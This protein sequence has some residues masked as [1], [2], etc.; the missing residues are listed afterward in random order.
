M[1]DLEATFAERRGQFLEPVARRLEDHL[2][3]C[4][5]SSARVDRIVA[6]AKRVDRFLAKATKVREDGSPKYQLP[7]A[8]I[9]DQIAARIVT[10]YLSDVSRISTEINRFFR[11]IERKLIVPDSENEFGYFGQHFILLIPTDVTAGLEYPDAPEF[12]ELQI[13]T[14]FQHAWAEAEHDVGYKPFTKL[15]SVHKRKIAFTA[16]Q[17]WG[18]DLIF[19]ELF[20]ELDSAP[21]PPNVV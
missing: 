6:R 16:A 15:T 3:N 7:L 9:Q 10:F 20:S 14:L 21:A 19:D 13:K 17:A 1:T 2:H 5:K 8:E 18:A 4:L 11:P 12:F